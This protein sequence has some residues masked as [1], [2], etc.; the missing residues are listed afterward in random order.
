MTLSWP[1][2][3]DGGGSSVGAVLL[4]DLHQGGQG[5]ASVIPLAVEQLFVAPKP[6]SDAYV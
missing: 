3:G 1:G 2:G 4:I 5:G 6:G